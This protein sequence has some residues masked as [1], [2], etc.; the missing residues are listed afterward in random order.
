MRLRQAKKVINNV[1]LLRTK[2][3]FQTWRRAVKS[4]LRAQRLVWNSM[5][6]K[7]VEAYYAN[8]F[9]L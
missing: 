6:E 9:G 3:P 2:Y 4:V 7:M 8:Y 1:E 5:S